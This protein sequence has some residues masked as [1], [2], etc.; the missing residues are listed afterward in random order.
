MCHS[1][2]RSQY[3]GSVELVVSTI[4]AA[5]EVGSGILRKLAHRE[6]DWA[7]CNILN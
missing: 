2:A 4:R 6:G 3:G 5:D 1:W 7:Y